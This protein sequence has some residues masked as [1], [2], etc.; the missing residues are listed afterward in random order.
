MATKCLRSSELRYPVIIKYTGFQRLSTKKRNV[1]YLNNNF[2]L[3]KERAEE[4][5]R[6]RER[7]EDS[8][9]PDVGP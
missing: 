2:F 8:V 4:G 5:H 3:V 7:K 9:E 6:E 1:K